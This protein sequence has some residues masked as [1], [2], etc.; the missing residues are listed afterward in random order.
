MYKGCCAFSKVVLVR[1]DDVRLK[2]AMLE[3]VVLK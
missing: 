3:A 2:L 1:F